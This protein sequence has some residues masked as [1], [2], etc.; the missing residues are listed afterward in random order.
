[1]SP[2]N[3]D[4]DSKTEQSWQGPLKTSI[5]GSSGSLMD[6]FSATLE[7]NALSCELLSHADAQA[8]MPDDILFAVKEL[9]KLST[10]LLLQETQPVS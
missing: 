2:A 6:I 9:R 3:L 7:V 4:D 8:L 5:S 1:M 10:D